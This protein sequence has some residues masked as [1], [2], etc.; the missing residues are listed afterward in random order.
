[1]ETKIYENIE[2][3]QIADFPKYFISECVKIY[4]EKSNK[5]LKPSSDDGY[6]RV[7]LCKDGKKYK[8]L[9]HRLLAEIFIPNPE[10]KP[11]IDHKNRIRTD[12]RLENLHWVTRKENNQNQSKKDT[13]LWQGVSY[14]PR[15]NR[16]RAQWRDENG[17]QCEVS[18]SYSVYGI[19][20]LLMA[21]NKREEMVKILYNRP[22]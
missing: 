6:F 17:K 8:K 14:Y 13:S 1:M 3:Y 19:F 7:Q 16:Y 5:I 20:A 9:V 21:I 2:F 18:Y 15:N 12:N 11:C 4:S 22:E 10:N